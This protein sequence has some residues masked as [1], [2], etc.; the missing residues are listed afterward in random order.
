MVLWWFGPFFRGPN[1]MY[2]HLWLKRPSAELPRKYAHVKRI[3]TNQSIYRI[4]ISNAN[5]FWCTM[6]PTYDDD[7]SA[8]TFSV[9][10]CTSAKPSCLA[11]KGT[12]RRHSL[13]FG[14]NNVFEID[15]ADDASHEDIWYSKEEYEIIKARNRVLVKMKRS[16][17]FEESDEHSFRGLE[18]KLKDGNE[19]RKAYKFDALNAVLEEQDRQ[20]NRGLKD[21]EDIARRYRET[22][23]AAQETAI[24]TALKDAEAVVVDTEIIVDVDD[25]DDDT[26]VVSDLQTVGSDDTQQK[27]TRLQHLFNGIS[28][29]KTRKSHRR[30]SM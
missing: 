3:L 24:I 29:M 6:P 13:T 4:E 12:R 23:S 7:Y 15:R 11:K 8:A 28:Q 9:S 18:H 27:K 26:S 5:C 30:A 1:L 25:Y 2:C 21:A 14:D 16:G 20:Y 19:Q 22:A 17:K 10:A